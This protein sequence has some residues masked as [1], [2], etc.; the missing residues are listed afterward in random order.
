MSANDRVAPGLAKGSLAALCVEKMNAALAAPGA[1][2]QDRRAIVAGRE[3][4]A[5]FRALPFGFANRG[6]N[7]R[8]SD[9]AIKPRLEIARVPAER[10]RRPKIDLLLAHDFARLNATNPGWFYPSQATLRAL[11]KVTV[12]T[13]GKIKAV[14][15]NRVP[16]G[17]SGGSAETAQHAFEQGRDG[18]GGAVLLQGA[19]DLDAT[20]HAPPA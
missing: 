2:G 10:L 20:G 16:K 3:E 14:G 19:D 13:V 18:D 4:R 7:R 12:K 1:Q 8:Q 5:N 9:F 17:Y 6:F 15:L 11:R